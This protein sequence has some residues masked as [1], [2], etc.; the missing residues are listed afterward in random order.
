MNRHVAILGAFLAL[1][2]APV[3]AGGDISDQI[4]SVRTVPLATGATTVYLIFDLDSWPSGD[5]F[6]IRH[7][8]PPGVEMHSQGFAILSR[9]TGPGPGVNIREATRLTNARNL[10]G[11]A[12]EQGFSW[13]VSNDGPT[14]G[15]VR[16]ELSFVARQVQ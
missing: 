16:L 5:T 6:I 8:C 7:F 4:T 11:N 9:P 15:P 12:G 14:S 13:Y 1:A 3:L 10:I 2:P